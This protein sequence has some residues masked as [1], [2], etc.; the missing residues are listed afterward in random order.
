V[1]KRQGGGEAHWTSLGGLFFSEQTINISPIDTVHAGEFKKYSVTIHAK[2]YREIR[3]EWRRKLH[4]ETTGTV[5]VWSRE[6]FCFQQKVWILEPHANYEYMIGTGRPLMVYV[7]LTDQ[8]AN[9]VPNTRISIIL[10]TERGFSFQKR[11]TFTDWSGYSL[12]YFNISDPLA[13]GPLTIKVCD[14]AKNEEYVA[15]PDCDKVEIE[16]VWPPGMETFGLFAI[17]DPNVV[18]PGDS[19]SYLV[20]IVPINNFEG[21]VELNASNL[22]E[23]TTA[24]FD[25]NVVNLTGPYEPNEAVGSLLT[26]QT[27]AAGAD[28]NATPPGFHRFMISATDGIE[29]RDF[30]CP[31]MILV[32]YDYDGDGIY[33]DGDN[34]G[35]IGDKPCPSYYPNCDDNCRM[36]ANTDQNDIDGDGVGDVCDNCPADYDPNQFDMDHDGVGDV[37]DRDPNVYGPNKCGDIATVYLTQDYND[38]CYINMEDFADFVYVWLQ[39]TNPRETDCDIYWR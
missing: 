31:L 14:V 6:N 19:K 17:P 23:G 4:E 34:S 39:C 22:P 15:D 28:A 2:I 16:V 8:L 33:D 5:T 11:D 35:V 13:V 24:V 36:T 3:D 29:T 38:D 32:G 26:I 18:A 9:A 37:C 20:G 12:E 25:P 7:R 1:Y 30:T 27:T 10:Y 21:D